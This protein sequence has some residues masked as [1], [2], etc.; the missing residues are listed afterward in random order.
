MPPLNCS[1]AQRKPMTREAARSTPDTGDM[2]HGDMDHGDMEMAP[3][4]IPLAEGAQDRDG[5]EM[6]VLHLGL[7]PVLAHWPAGVRLRCV[8]S[9]DVV[10]EATVALLD[11]E[12]RPAPEPPS[13]PG[14]VT[15][16]STCSRW[17]AGP[18]ER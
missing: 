13:W 17:P 14:S 5:L 4:G 7:G 3:S 9:G 1:T 2:D 16:S 8:L 18:A 15:T 6:D 12:H 11:A 10:T